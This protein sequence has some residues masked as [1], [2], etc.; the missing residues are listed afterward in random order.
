MTS[1]TPKRTRPEYQR[2]RITLSS[3]REV[4]VHFIP[5]SAR[6]EIDKRH[7]MPE[8]PIIEEETA[9]GR[10]IRVLI[11][12]DPDYLAEVAKVNEARD[13]AWQEGYSLLALRGVKI[14]D[15]FD[16]EEELGEILC[17]LNPK[18]KP[19]KGKMGRR[20]DYIEYVLLENQRDAALVTK[21]LGEMI[22]VDEE[23]IEAIEDSFQGNVS[24]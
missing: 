13:L 10:V 22:G 18:W 2:T 24:K 4:D 17:Y 5:S 21:T 6:D 15:D 9:T 7:P 23:V 20:L 3:G 16:L 12:D 14:P 8:P 1:P 11:E 19:R